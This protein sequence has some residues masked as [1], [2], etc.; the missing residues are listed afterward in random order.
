MA[1]SPVIDVAE[2]GS[3]G[4]RKPIVRLKSGELRHLKHHS[5][6]LGVAQLGLLCG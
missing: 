1:R 4:K 5:N 6:A 3:C 2:E